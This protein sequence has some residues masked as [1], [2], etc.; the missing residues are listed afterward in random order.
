MRAGRGAGWAAALLAC[1][2]VACSQA[3]ASPCDAALGL[4]ESQCAAVRALRLPEALPAARGNQYADV[5]AAAQLGF[6]VFFQA[7]VGHGVS[8]ATCHDPSFDFTDRTPVST[9]KAQGTRNAPTTLNAARLKVLFWDGRADSVW[10]QALSP[11]ENPAE[12]DT[13]RLEVAHYLAGRA[14]FKAL[15]ETAFGPYPDVSGLPAQGKPGDAAFDG[16]SAAER[17]SVNRVFA[18]LGKA[19]EA[20]E[21]K[22]SS[23]P[24]P[25]DRYLDGDGAAIIDAA[26]RGLSVFAQKG[27]IACHAGPLL[28]DEQFHAV[29]LADSPSGAPDPGAL[30]GVQ[31]LAHS[32]FSL[33]GPYADA[34]TGMTGPPPAPSGAVSGAFRTPSLRSVSVTAPYGHGGTYASLG[35]LL[36]VHASGLSDDD[37]G[38]LIAFLR[39][40]S[41]DLPPRPWSTWPS[42]Q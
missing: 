12:M 21:R 41:G 19:I 6:L 2:A 13:S 37:R 39:T 1:L 35:E 38:A 33:S 34:D 22:N 10:S 16:L 24:A 17:D 29:G 14:D 32:E 26:K 23:G 18:N 31:L 5:P 25:I 40:L 27:C 30:E 15:Y 7:D 3:P 36:A 28:T 11:L 20:Y 4:D 9:G 8:C 42:T